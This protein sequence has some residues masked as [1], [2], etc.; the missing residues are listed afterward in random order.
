MT[1][2]KKKKKST[3]NQKY[4]MLEKRANKLLKNK[5]KAHKDAD[6]E[7][8]DPEVEPYFLKHLDRIKGLEDSGISGEAY[9]LAVLKSMRAL[10]LELIPVAEKNYR[11]IPSHTAASAMNQYI[12]QERELLVDIRSL[13]SFQERA[14]KIVSI[15][16]DEY[17]SITEAIISGVQEMERRY[18]KSKS[19]NTEVKEFLKEHGSFLK[20][21]RERIR[22][23]VLELMIPTDKKRGRS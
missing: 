19:L 17:M 12:S 23:N 13:E 18:N 7:D 6:T 2:L 11:L 3:P 21:S 10:V 1:L 8:D 4:A 16:T 9:D 5:A 22:A 20:A 14:E 15:M